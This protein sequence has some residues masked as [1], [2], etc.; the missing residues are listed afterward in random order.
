LTPIDSK[1]E[2]GI[3]YFLQIH[4]RSATICRSQAAR[5]GLPADS[6]SGRALMEAAQN[7]TRRLAA[8]I[9]IVGTQMGR[10]VDPSTARG[11]IRFKLLETDGTVVQ[12]I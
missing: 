6:V 11:P 12:I 3:L 1:L 5:H 2:E 7:A 10:P 4:G 9:R 8:R